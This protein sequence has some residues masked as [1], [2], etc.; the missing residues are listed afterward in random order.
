[1]RRSTTIDPEYGPV[2]ARGIRQHTVVSSSRPGKRDVLAQPSWPHK[3][4]TCPGSGSGSSSGSGAGA[5][6][7]RV[8]TRICY[9]RGNIEWERSWVDEFPDG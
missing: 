3:P 8:A 4:V 5:L 2:C 6:M 9:K 1:M 7:V